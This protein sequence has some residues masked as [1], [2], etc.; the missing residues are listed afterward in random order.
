M[1]IKNNDI[2]KMNILVER[3]LHAKYLYKHLIDSSKQNINEEKFIYNYIHRFYPNYETGCLSYQPKEIDDENT[4]ISFDDNM[5]DK[6]YF[7]KGFVLECDSSV[8]VYFNKIYE[9]YDRNFD[10]DQF[11]RIVRDGINFGDID[12]MNV[13]NSE[14][15]TD[16]RLKEIS[17]KL[18][19][20]SWEYK[21]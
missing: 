2:I 9:N 15:N 18:M 5:I 4:W 20:Y 8:S 1:R 13:Y 17:R 16:S 14:Y 11:F 21:K 3:Y 7:E 6:Y 10:T 12:L 19:E